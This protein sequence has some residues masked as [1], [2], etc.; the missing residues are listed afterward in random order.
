MTVLNIRN[1]NKRFHGQYAKV[2]DDFCL[3]I[4]EGDFCILLGNNGSGKSTLLK[5]ISGDYTVDSGSI[6]LDNQ[7]I[8][9]RSLTSRSQLISMVVQD[10]TLG[11]V[12]EMSLLEN[13]A[14]SIL[15]TTKGSFKLYNRHRD[16]IFT[17]LK[18]LNIGL[19][20]YIDKPI[21]VLSGG[22]RQ[23]IATVMSLIFEPRILLLDEHTSA[24]DP[25][26]HKI[27]MDYTTKIIKEK[28]ITT[29]MIT[30]HLDDALKYGNRL[31]FLRNGKVLKDWRDNKKQTLEKDD[32]TKL[33]H[34]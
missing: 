1:I 24:L 29:I 12:K 33:F 23:I 26:T 32:L 11:V 27:L 3:E 9:Q 16:Y 21:G 25:K 6:N 30:H 15:R 20:Q 2:L 19:E 4:K 28:N 18:E 31:I 10:V 8:T 34:M 7:E 13:I 17:A 22:Q 14:L 5:A